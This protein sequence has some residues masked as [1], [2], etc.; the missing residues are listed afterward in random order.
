M[1]NPLTLRRGQ[2]RAALEWRPPPCDPRQAL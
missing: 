2:L 1:V